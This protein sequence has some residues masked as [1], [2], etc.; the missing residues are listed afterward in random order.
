MKQSGSGTYLITGG[1]GFIGSH[2]VDLLLAD[3]ATKEVR[4]LDNF[5]SGRREHLAHWE[6][7]PRLTVVA[8]ELLQLEEVTRHFVGVDCVFHL[9]A[10]PDARIGIINTRLDLEQ[11]TIVTYN[12]VEA[13]RRSGVQKIVFSSSGTVYGD[14]GETATD[15]TFGPCLPI[16]LYGAGKVASEAL[17]SA[18]CGTF[19]MRAVIFR[20]GNIV[21]ERATHGAIFDFIRQL[22]KNSRELT[23]LGNGYQA[24]PYVY[25]R[26]LVKGLVF[27]SQ[28]C[29]KLASAEFKVF[30]IAP[31]DATSV[32]FIAEQ[33]VEG[34]GFKNKTQIRYGDSSR[35]WAGDVPQVRM[36][37]SKL[38]NSGFLLSRNSD[39]AVR[40]AIDQIIRWLSE[41]RSNEDEFRMPSD[42]SP[43]LG[44]PME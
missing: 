8:V 6:S 2:L 16:S 9:A 11:E 44:S 15:E 12:V 27:G 42:A 4:V 20:F 39:E 34:L 26:D 18:F 13:M 28:E 19:G 14:V 43:T 41:R 33:L 25:V 24:K 35:G 7:D 32:R 3:S 5:S 29:E 21:G 1:A 10:N 23:V 30:N 36:N 31:P 22:V 37:A 38:Q 17:I 40:V